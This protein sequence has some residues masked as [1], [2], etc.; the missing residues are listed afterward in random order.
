MVRDSSKL[1]S[2]IKS[3]KRIK[4][5]ICDLRECNRFRNDIN[6]INYLIHT[7]TAW[8][9]PKRT[10]EVNITAFEELLSLL[11]LNILKKIIYFSTASILDENIELMRESLIYGT[12]YIQTKYKCYEWLKASNFSKK[13]Y[14]I[15]PTL[16]FGGTLDKKSFY[17]IS[18][19][20]QGL[21]Q[22]QEWLWLARFFSVDSKFH[23]IHAKDIAQICGSLVINITKGEDHG[24]KKFVL[25]QNQ[26][27]INQAIDI[28]LKE[29][30]MKRFFSI[31]LK[32][33]IIKILLKVLPIQATSW[34]TFSIKK[35]NFHHK[36]ITTPETL[37]LKSYAKTLNRVIKLAKLP[38]CNIN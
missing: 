31:P 9:D 20:T 7:A 13:S 37:G 24:F 6:K 8:G 38:R 11:D 14:V 23:F 12:E 17:P 4:L 5:L 25:G 15:F 27:T 32:R 36:P 1:P 3:N 22:A 29:K 18:Y 34:D 19:L 16:V 21:K 2:I 28:L 30:G 33:R 26:I 35:Y 10:Y